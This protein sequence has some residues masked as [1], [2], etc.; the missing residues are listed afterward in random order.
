MQSLQDFK[1]SLKEIKFLTK[2][3]KK[4][5]SDRWKYQL[6][7]KTS[8]ILLITKFE[9][10]VEDAIDE[11]IFN[12]TKN[13]Q[14]TNIPT[15]VKE[16]IEIDLIANK[17][18]DTLNSEKRIKIITNL[19]KIHNQSFK[20][21][22]DYDHSLKFNV[23]KHGEKELKRL[24]SEIGII[25]DSKPNI[26]SIF[27]NFNSLNNIRNNVIHEDVSPNITHQQVIKYS[28]NLLKISQYIKEEIENQ[29]TFA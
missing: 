4:F 15:R 9:V 6:Y 13:N 10:F 8:I 14:S 5:Q 7:N 19:M 29:L 22:I 26:N 20:D 18:K 23:G 21:L 12:C 11:F 2:N 16:F 25:L 17:T 24:L 28:L 3:A 27:A 1:Q